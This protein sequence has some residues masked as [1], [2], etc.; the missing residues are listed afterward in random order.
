MDLAV[1]GA[2]RGDGAGA[3][4]GLE[5]VEAVGDDLFGGEEGVVLV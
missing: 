5:F 4:V 3:D 1:F 2:V